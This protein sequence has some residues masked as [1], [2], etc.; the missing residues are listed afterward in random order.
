[1]SRRLRGT[2][3]RSASVAACHP[4]A[5]D[6]GFARLIDGAGASGKPVW[7]D[8]S[9]NALRDAVAAAPSGI[10]INVGEASSI[11]NQ[12]IKNKLQPSYNRV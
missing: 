9:G 4:G 3:M 1:M 12:N 6:G 8:T 10:K 5:P 2:R 11:L 7:V